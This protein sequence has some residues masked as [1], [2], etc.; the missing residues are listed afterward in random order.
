MIGDEDESDML[1][2]LL[3]HTLGWVVAAAERRHLHSRQRPGCDELPIGS[4]TA[5][6]LRIVTLMDLWAQHQSIIRQMS[7]RNASSSQAEGQ[8]VPVLTFWPVCGWGG[9]VCYQRILDELGRRDFNVFVDSL[10][11]SKLR[12]LSILV[13]KGH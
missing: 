13:I 6:S 8:A 12:K 7:L 1:Y 3:Q 9:G 2:G 10:R 4:C 11:F 5:T